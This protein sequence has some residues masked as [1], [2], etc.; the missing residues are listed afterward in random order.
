MKI[1]VFGKKRTSKD[2]RTF[3]TYLSTLTKKDGSEVSVEVKFKEECGNPKNVPCTIEFDKK[4]ANYSEKVETYVDD[5]MEEK[6]TTRR[7]LW[8][9]KYTESTYI[10]ESMNDF[11]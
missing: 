8:V 2:G 10:D 5:N 4:D 7:R 3:Y 9:N 1:N 11:V 6:E